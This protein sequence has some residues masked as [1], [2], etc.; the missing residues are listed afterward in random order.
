M[1]PAYNRASVYDTSIIAYFPQFISSF[2]PQMSLK[3]NGFKKI[4]N[5]KRG[6][7]TEIPAKPKHSLV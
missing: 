2:L 5:F 4:E 3:E 6:L 7:Q 1:E